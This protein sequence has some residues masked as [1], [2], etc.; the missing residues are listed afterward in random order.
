MSRPRSD[1]RGGGGVGPGLG[2]RVIFDLG[3][4]RTWY[5]TGRNLEVTTGLG[6]VI[7]AAALRHLI[8]RFGRL[9]AACGFALFVERLHVERRGGRRA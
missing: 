5:Y 2:R 4:V 1:A 6:H 7:G 3:L 9:A 8:G